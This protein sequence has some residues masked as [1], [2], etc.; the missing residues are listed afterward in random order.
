[1]RRRLTSTMVVQL[2]DEVCRERGESDEEELHAGAPRDWRARGV[3]HAHDAPPTFTLHV[4]VP[5]DH[6][7]VKDVVRQD[8]PPDRAPLLSLDP[9]PRRRRARLR[10]ARLTARNAA[11][12]TGPAPP[13][14]GGWSGGRGTSCGA[15]RA[16]G[17]PDWNGEP[18]CSFQ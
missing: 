8:E 3:E 1:M 15:R 2:R 11:P 10:A 13:V 14:S 18:G 17:G 16:V 9:V 7:H 4:V 12:P 6:D 5:P